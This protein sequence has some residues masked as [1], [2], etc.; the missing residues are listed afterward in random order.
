MIEIVIFILAS[1]LFYLQIKKIYTEKKSSGNGI[2][3]GEKTAQRAEDEFNIYEGVNEEDLIKSYLEK[4]KR[5]SKAG[6]YRN[7]E[8]MYLE[9]IKKDP[10][11]IDAYK[12]LGKLFFDDEN[13]DEATSYFEKVTVLDESDGESWTNLGIIYHEMEQFKKSVYAYERAIEL[14]KKDPTKFMNLAIVYAKQNDL[15]EAATTL[16]KSLKLKPTKDGYKFLYSIYK[17]MGDINKASKAK[18]ILEELEKTK[19]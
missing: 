5:L 15:E 7:A 19:K 9:V 12:G 11:N 2:T 1:T 14:D 13:F 8:N 17:K 6:A 3:V 4:A 16:E 10:K 18:K